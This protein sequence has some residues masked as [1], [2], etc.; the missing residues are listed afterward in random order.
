MSS[1]E[2]RRSDISRHFTASGYVVHQGCVLLHWHLKVGAL[3]PPGGHIEPNEDPVETVLR[4]IKEET[5]LTVEVLSP[6]LPLDVAYPI[7]VSPPET[8]MVEDIQDP[9]AGPR[10]KAARA[11]A[12]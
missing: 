2:P 10:S 12:G 1:D 11:A 4:E 5:G 9:E 6:Q 7:Q 3:L 8:I